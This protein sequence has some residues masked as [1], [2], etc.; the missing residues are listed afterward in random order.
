MVMRNKMVFIEPP[1]ALAWLE[2]VEDNPRKRTSDSIIDRYARDMREDRWIKGEG[3]PIA[4]TVS[5]KLKNGKH[6][7]YACIQAGVGF[8]SWV[9]F[10]APEDF[11]INTDSGL[12]RSLGD[13]IS[14]ALGGHAKDTVRIAAGIRLSWAMVSGFV[15]SYITKAPSRGEALDHFQK[16]PSIV[17]AYDFWS[18]V[19]H[20]RELRGSSALTAFIHQA[21][22]V[23]RDAAELFC[24]SIHQ[25]KDGAGIKAFRHWQL[26]NIVLVQ[27]GKSRPEIVLQLAV[28]IKAWNAF[29]TGK[30][31]QMLRWVRGGVTPEE[32]PVMKNELGRS[33]PWRNELD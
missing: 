22:L 10:D 32:F 26:H 2:H 31:A 33:I 5:G 19:T 4:L 28:L 20:N 1:Q 17:Q 29:V 7:L 15:P 9:I 12:A 25:D 13:N 8:W 30:P 16:N 3:E 27:R 6:R 11:G 24:W 14:N 18:P 21:M 23:D